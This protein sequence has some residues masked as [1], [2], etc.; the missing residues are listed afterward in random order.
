MGVLITFLV[1]LVSWFD[2]FAQAVLTYYN[3]SEKFETLLIRFA[4][5][6]IFTNRH[7]LTRLDEDTVYKKHYTAT[8]TP[9][10]T[11]HSDGKYCT[12]PPRMNPPRRLLVRRR[13]RCCA[14]VRRRAPPPRRC[15][16]DIGCIQSR[17]NSSLPKPPPVRCLDALDV[18]WRCRRT[19][20]AIAWSVRLFHS[21]R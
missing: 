9:A 18:R 11:S 12:L 7:L 3:P 20:G 6:T 8:P 13:R 10:D 16:S 1:V 5:I 19:V 17:T 15:T 2:V 21:L 4:L 14:R